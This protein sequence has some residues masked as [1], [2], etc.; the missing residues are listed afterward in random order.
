MAI[1]DIPEEIIQWGAGVLAGTVVIVGKL[2]HGRLQRVEEKQD[3]LLNLINQ[4]EKNRLSEN[5]TTT[6]M[7]KALTP[8]HDNINSLH[9]ET[10]NI[11]KLLIEHLLNNGNNQK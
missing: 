1:K 9:Q 6:Q 5:P 4:H 11:H 8:L 7:E 10:S 3:K 2:F